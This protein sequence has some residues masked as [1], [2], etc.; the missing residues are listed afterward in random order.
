MNVYPSKAEEYRLIHRHAIKE[1]KAYAADDSIE[2]ERLLPLLAAMASDD[3]E[4]VWPIGADVLP[5]Y[6]ACSVFIDNLLVSC[7]RNIS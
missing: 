3:L 2:S 6:A 5:Q 7:E 1:L 4:T